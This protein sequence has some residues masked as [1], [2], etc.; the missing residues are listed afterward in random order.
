MGKVRASVQTEGIVQGVGFRPFIYDLARRHELTGWVLNDEQGVQIE[1]EG[2]ADRVASFI[3]DLSAPPPLAVVEQ[4]TINYVP[5]IG[6][7]AF[8][9]RTSVAG[10]ERFAL[11]SPDMATCDDCRRELFDPRDRRFRYPFINCTNCGPRFTIIEDIPYDRPKTTMAPFAMCPDCSREYHDPEDR[12]FHAQP[13]A[14][15]LCGPQVKLL[16]NTGEAV[17][18]EDPIRETIALLTAGKIVAIKGLGGFHLACDAAHEE[19]VALL[20][21][22]KYREDKPFALMCRDIEVIEGICL[23][24]DASRELLL[25]R[26]RPIVILPRREDTVIAR[27][28]APGQRT[29]GVMLPY[30]PLHY[31]LLSDGADGLTSL[32]MTSGNVSD[33]PIAYQDAEAVTRLGGIADSFLVH[34]REIH[35]RC[36]D[37]VVKPFRGKRTFLRRARGYVP[38]PIRL[39]LGLQL[40]LQKQGRSVLACGAE[41]KNTFCLTKGN[42]AFLSHHIGDLENFETMRSFEEGITLMKRLFQIEPEAV[43]HDLHP[44][45]LATRSALAYAQERE[46][47]RIGVQHHFAHALSCMAEHGIEGPALAVV[48]DGTGYGED[49]TVWGGEFLQVTVDG[50][51]RLGHLR[52]IPLPG[53]DKAAKEPWRMGA[54]YLDRVYGKAEDAGIPFTQSLDLTQWSLIREAML[55]GINAPL[56]SSTGRLFDAVSALLGV[57]ERVNYEG[58]AAIELEQMADSGEKGEYGLEIAEEAGVYI[59]N[60]DPVITAIVEAIKKGETPGAISARFHNSL[61][62]GIVK[63]ALQMKERTGLSEVILSGGVFQ[64]HL[65]MGA[66]Y[67]LLEGEDFQVYIHHKVPPNDGGIALGQAFHAIHLLEQ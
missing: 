62:R 58:Q 5:P 44:D 48:M 51:I 63:M 21:G 25:S 11:V 35:T 7:T 40:Q 47:P 1:V 13:N 57:R 45:Y 32:V 54:A 60:P 4:T 61:A 14:C 55:S 66:V 50:Y 9:I 38:F 20:R 59:L 36:D 42:Y 18:S 56:C 15:P 26:E 52:T 10:Q 3:S 17:S 64:N 23:V 49:G 37:S 6:S 34:D 39:Q 33:E 24:D 65:L 8:Q 31:L 27:S 12:R 16:D 29:L 41:L 46:V 2:E 30:A 67:D 53:G 22:R 19:A 43:V 28:V